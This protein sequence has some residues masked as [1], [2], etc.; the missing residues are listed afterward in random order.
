MCNLPQFTKPVIETEVWKPDFASLSITRLISERVCLSLKPTFFP[1]S[2]GMVTNLKQKRKLVCFSKLSSAVIIQN[3]LQVV[4][5]YSERHWLSHCWKSDKYKYF[6]GDTFLLWWSFHTFSDSYFLIG[7]KPLGTH[8]AGLPK[9]SVTPFFSHSC[10]PKSPLPLSWVPPEGNLEPDPVNRLWAESA[11]FS[12]RGMPTRLSMTKDNQAMA[13]R[14]SW[15][16]FPTNMADGEQIRGRCGSRAREPAQPGS[17]GLHEETAPIP[18]AS[19][20]G[21]QRMMIYRLIASQKPFSFENIPAIFW[22]EE[23]KSQN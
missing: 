21:P 15:C 19:Q 8:P 23:A 10:G 22:K 11:F 17:A 13:M 4:R 9:P 6:K 1:S 7:S 2:T 3:L 12:A 16:S 18:P 14:S 20:R 5:K